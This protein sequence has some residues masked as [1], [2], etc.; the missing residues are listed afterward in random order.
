MSDMQPRDEQT[1]VTED[2]AAD[3]RRT[4][5]LPS[6]AIRRPV[7]TVMLSLV[8]VVLGMFYLGRLPLDLCRP[9]SIRRSAPA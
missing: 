7:G 2:A 6:L 8:V 9:S 1:T 5:G 3:A 4:R